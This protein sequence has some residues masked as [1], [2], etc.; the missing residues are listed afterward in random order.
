MI[1]KGKK[2]EKTGAEIYNLY[3]DMIKVGVTPEQVMLFLFAHMNKIK[4][5]EIGMDMQDSLGR[6]F[7][8]KVLLKDKPLDECENTEE[9][10][11]ATF[12]N[13]MTPSV[14]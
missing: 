5:K 9:N 10:K 3:A 6:S 2:M 13:G 11:I 7:S 8:M 14:V 1:K 4:A 12:K